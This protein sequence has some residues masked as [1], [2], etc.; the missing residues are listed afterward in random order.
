MQGLI[1]LFNLVL[2]AT[3]GMAY[4]S[5]YLDPRIFWW[6]ALSGLVFPALVILQVLFV[7]YWFG[8]RRWIYSA[9]AVLALLP[10]GRE[11]PHYL[12]WG[13][14]EGEA[15]QQALE[16]VAQAGQEAVSTAEGVPAQQTGQERWELPPTSTQ[17]LRV[18]SWNVRVFN[19]N[20]DPRFSGRDEMVAQMA[21]SQADVICLQEYFTF[22]GSDDHDHQ[23]AIR[24]ASGLKHHKLWEALRDENGR[25]WG[26]AIYSRY[27][28]LDAGVL[29][30]EEHG[31]LNGAHYADIEHPVLGRLRLFNAHLQ[32]IQLATVEY[33]L[34]DALEEMRDANKR[35]GVLEK[36]RRGYEL[37]AAQASTLE[38]AVRESP[39]PVVLCG[40]FN[41]PPQSYAYQRLA[42]ELNDAFALA[43]KGI[44]RTHIN[45]PAVR[46]DYV[47]LHPSLD[48]LHYVS[49]PSQLSDHYPVLVDVYRKPTP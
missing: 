36:F 35:R 48:A 20:S 19:K 5:P 27:P 12:R 26:L 13:G 44:A 38:D 40:D 39:W 3:L 29:T 47:L 43:G 42:Y 10:A 6:P 8:S 22:P 41:D 31:I 33:G 34:D 32:S 14:R 28:I 24:E 37:R 2:M 11:L 45:L 4:A 7:L 9:V 30:F 16:S 15:L 49:P 25:K 21:H 1:F 23:R 46:I 17:A 18:L